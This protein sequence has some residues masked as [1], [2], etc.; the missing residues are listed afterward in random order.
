MSGA[1]RPRSPGSSSAIDG[2]LKGLAD[3]W[4]MR[5]PLS[6]PILSTST[7]VDT[8]STESRLTAL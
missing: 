4:R 3:L 6:A 1:G 2:D 8:D 5:V 7:S